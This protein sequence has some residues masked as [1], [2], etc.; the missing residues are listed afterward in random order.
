VAG[1][2]LGPRQQRH[3]PLELARRIEPGRDLL[4][5]QVQLAFGWRPSV[6]VSAED[7]AAHSIRREKSVLDALSER[8]LEQRVA[9]VR[10]RVRGL[11]ALRRSGHAKLRRGREVL[12]D[13]PP[14]GRDAGAAAVA[15]VD[16]HEVEEVRRVVAEDAVVLIAA[17]G[18]RLVEGEVDLAA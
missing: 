16:D 2:G 5:E 10:I 12:E 13:P 4:T 7:D 18:D 1:G 15:L 9:E 14:R 11:V 6:G 3:D 17:V 8:V